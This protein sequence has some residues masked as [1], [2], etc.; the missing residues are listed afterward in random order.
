MTLPEFLADILGRNQEM[1]KMTLADFSD[2]DML[3]R[4]APS[5]NHAAWQ[6]GH[7]IVAEAGI[8]NGEKPDTVPLPA[9]F[10]EK[11][12]KE[13]ATSNDAKAFPS[14]AELLDAFAKS[15]AAT[16]AW[17]KSLK[18]EDL[19]RPTVG[20][21][22]RMAPTHAHLAGLQAD[23]TTMHVGQFQVIRRA[24]GKPVLF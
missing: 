11:F 21:I 13:T 12:S 10:R 5:A 14:K 16:V 20:N 1:L 15:R 22:K 2:Q 8:I 24:L 3:A 4:P 23:H 17:V 6:L 18:P 19:D 9:G 7:L